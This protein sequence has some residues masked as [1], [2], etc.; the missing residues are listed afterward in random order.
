[1]NIP[2]D[3]FEPGKSLSITDMVNVPSLGEKAKAEDQS[4]QDKSSANAANVHLNEQ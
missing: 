1:L 4:G 2:A 3:A